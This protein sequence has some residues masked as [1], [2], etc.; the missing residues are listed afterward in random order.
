MVTFK[1]HTLKSSLVQQTY[2][3]NINMLLGSI[4]CYQTRLDKTIN[5]ISSS[6]KDDGNGLFK[7]EFVQVSI[8]VN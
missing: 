3:T 1:V 8:T 5:I 2:N 4:S 6:I 7:V